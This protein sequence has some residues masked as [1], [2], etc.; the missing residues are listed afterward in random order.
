MVADQA[1]IR[2][3]VERRDARIATLKSRAAIAAIAGFALHILDAGNG[4]ASTFL[5]S[6]WGRSVDLPDVGAVERFLEQAGAR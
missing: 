3:E 4:T 2:V 1:A 6:R 5:M